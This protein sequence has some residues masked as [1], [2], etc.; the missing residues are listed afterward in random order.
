LD[1]WSRRR[2]AAHAYSSPSGSFNQRAAAST[3]AIMVTSSKSSAVGSTAGADIR[4]TLD[5]RLRS[6]AGGSM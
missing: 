2:A 3:T 5:T 6:T 4:R 1:S